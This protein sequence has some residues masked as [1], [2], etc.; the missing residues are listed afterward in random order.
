MLQL[1]ITA[2]TFFLNYMIVEAKTPEEKETIKTIPDQILDA[3]KKRILK[4]VITD[5][6][7]YINTLM[8]NEK[9]HYADDETLKIMAKRLADNEMQC[10]NGI[11]ERFQDNFKILKET[12]E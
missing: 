5:C 3:W 6:D 10:F 7:G 12:L 8:Q 9:S 4:T 1:E 11:F 2:F